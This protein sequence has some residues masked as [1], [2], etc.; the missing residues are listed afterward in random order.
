[1]CWRSDT[2]LQSQEAIAPVQQIQPTAPTAPQPSAPAFGSFFEQRTVPSQPVTTTQTVADPVESSP[3]L[4]QSDQH[5]S[6]QTPEKPIVSPWSSDALS[7]F[8]KMPDLSKHR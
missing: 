6:T 5:D 3:E 1:M 4:S 8:K 2:L 7:R